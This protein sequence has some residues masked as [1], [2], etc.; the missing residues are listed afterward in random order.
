M[1]DESR[2]KVE[3]EKE[4][5]RFKGRRSGRRLK[6]RRSGR[7]LKGREGVKLFRGGIRK[8]GGKDVE[9]MGRNK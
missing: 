6:D 1:R 9:G 2:V 8:E 5:R 7:R 3:G 4:W